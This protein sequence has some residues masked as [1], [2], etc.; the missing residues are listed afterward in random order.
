MNLGSNIKKIREKKGLLQKQ[1]ASELGIGHTNYNKME[2]GNR[3]PSVSELQKLAKLFN[4]SIDEI[5]NDEGELPNDITLE[6]KSSI[7]QM[8]LIKELDEEDRAIVF[9]II[10]IM[11]TKKKFK[12]FF[13]K[14]ITQL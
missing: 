6:D 12:E 11:L 8:S 10:D 7:E 5:I 3:E 2:N 14:N 9:K 13:Q 1:V 4:M